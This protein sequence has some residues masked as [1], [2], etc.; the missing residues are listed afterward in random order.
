MSAE[1]HTKFHKEVLVRIPSEAYTLQSI[2]WNLQRSQSFRF[3]SL[4][5]H[6]WQCFHYSLHGAV[7]FSLRIDRDGLWA[8]K[9]PVGFLAFVSRICFE[10]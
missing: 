10:I 5:M 1:S 8:I 4:H 6:M 2:V 3:E 7:D 9:L